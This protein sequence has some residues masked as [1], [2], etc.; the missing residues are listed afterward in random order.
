VA[1]GDGPPHAK[2]IK[3]LSGLDKLR[4]PLSARRKKQIVFAF[5]ICGVDLDSPI[6][7]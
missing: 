3:T 4:A 2:K 6:Q 7:I 1:R 5:Q